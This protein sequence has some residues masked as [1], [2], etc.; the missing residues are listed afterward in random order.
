M[1]EEGWCIFGLGKYFACHSWHKNGID[2]VL[3]PLSPLYCS[4]F[5]KK[6]YLPGYIR[7]CSVVWPAD[8]LNRSFVVVPFSRFFFVF[9]STVFI[10][11]QN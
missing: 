4:R 9:I 7:M 11:E 2:C 3:V 6:L 10:R 1:L 5:Y 8:R